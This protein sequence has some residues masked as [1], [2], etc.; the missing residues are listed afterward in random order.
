MIQNCV[1]VENELDVRSNSCLALIVG[2]CQSISP[3]DGDQLDVVLLA[4]KRALS[5]VR[6]LPRRPGYLR[7]CASVA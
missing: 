7:G 1:A 6:P 5:I 4:D 2:V 3:L